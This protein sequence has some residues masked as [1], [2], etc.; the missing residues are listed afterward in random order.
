MLG[1]LAKQRCCWTKLSQ[2]ASSNTQLLQSSTEGSNCKAEA[3]SH[4]L[5]LRN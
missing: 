5:L 1:A 2:L 3:K 4:C